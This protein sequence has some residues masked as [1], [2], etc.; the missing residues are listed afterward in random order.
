MKKL[1]SIMLVMSLLLSACFI[2]NVSAEGSE[3]IVDG[4]K[5][6]E[7]GTYCA[8]TKYGQTRTTDIVIPKEVDFNGK[9]LP[10]V[11]IDIS[12]FSDCRSI[13][14]VTIPDSI[15]SIGP[16]AFSGCWS[17]VNVTIPGSVTYIG[18]DV[19]VGCRGLTNVVIENGVS[20]MGKY[21]F[22]NCSSLTSVTIPDSVMSI[23]EGAFCGCSLTRVTIPDSVKSIGDDAFEYC[24][25]LTSVT[26]SASLTEICRD[27]F[28]GA[29]IKTVYFKGTEEQWNNVWIESGNDALMTAKI[30]FNYDGSVTAGDTNGDGEIDNKDVVVLFRYVSGSGEYDAVYDFDGDGEVNNK[31]VV[32]LFREVS[33]AN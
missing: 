20:Q 24:R 27:A 15:T 22:L 3:V 23:S 25:D 1:I 33:A 12:A 28:N 18:W 5:Y 10:V 14:S 32:A 26:M 8:L 17:L 16:D 19:F 6:T 21:M 31:D 4:I 11:Q 9:R 7:Y 2:T 30:I 29:P 13:T